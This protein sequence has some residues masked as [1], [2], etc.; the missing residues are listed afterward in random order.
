MH[1]AELPFKE[2]GPQPPFDTRSLETFVSAPR[3]GILSYS[4]RDGTPAQTPIWYRY[5][6]GRFQM[7]TSATSPKAKALTRE[8]KACLTIQD[9]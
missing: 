5:R 7:L 3:V 8:Q 6:D 4:K 9:E 2:M 1:L